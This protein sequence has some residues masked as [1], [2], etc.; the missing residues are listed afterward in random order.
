MA[1]YYDYHTRQSWEESFGNRIGASEIAIIC[2]FS[3][4][5]SKTELWKEKTG[6]KTPDDISDNDLVAYGKEAEKYLRGLFALKHKDKYDV[7]YHEFRVYYNESDPFLTATLDGELTEKETGR[8]GIYEC[9]TCYIKSKSALEEWQFNKIPDK[10]YC[11]ICQQFHVTDFDFAV[12]NAEL[13]FPDGKAEIREYTIERTDIEQ[14]IEYVVEQG[15]EFWEDY[16]VTDIE[17]P[18]TFRL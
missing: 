9:K 5:K 6:R 18:V 12:L 10:Y 14:D 17:P 3:H 13:R 8:R 15:R 4:F 16:V 1:K 11:Q 2:G 7:E